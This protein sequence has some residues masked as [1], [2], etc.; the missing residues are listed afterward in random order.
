ML[1]KL[2]IAA[3]L[4][5][6][7]TSLACEESNQVDEGDGTADADIAEEANA[8]INGFTTGFKTNITER[9]VKVRTPRGG[10]CTGEVIAPRA[11]LTARH[12]VTTDGTIFGPLGDAEDMTIE[13]SGETTRIVD[14]VQDHDSLDVALLFVSESLTNYVD[15]DYDKFP[16]PFTELSEQRFRRDDPDLISYIVD[17]YGVNT[18]V[19]T[20]GGV[21]RWGY[22]YVD[23]YSNNM[24]QVDIEPGSTGQIPFSGDS[25]SGLWDNNNLERGPAVLGGVASTAACGVSTQYVTTIAIREWAVRSLY[26]YLKWRSSDHQYYLTDIGS[27]GNGWPAKSGGSCSSMNWTVEDG[28]T[29]EILENSNCGDG[30]RG[31][32]YVLNDAVLNNGYFSAYIKSTDDDEM[33]IAFRIQDKD[34]YYIAS[35]NKHADI[36]SIYRVREGDRE[37]LWQKNTTIDYSSWRHLMVYAKD[38]SFTFYWDG[39]RQGNVVDNEHDVM[40]SGGV[41]LYER[42]QANA[43]Y[44]QTHLQH[45]P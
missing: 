28:L 29:G 37:T 45:K 27:K 33:G 42:A 16:A 8:V 9:V 35:V 5:V 17:G 21:E 38:D 41:G 39:S 14:D 10:T 25:G 15:W 24:Q 43:R 31:A 11:V 4:G 32:L 30:E 20:G 7:V 2:I 6:G 44:K 40:L 12:C 22:V 3:M 1:R 34:N 26:N 36:M 23:F 13:K 18:C 19:G